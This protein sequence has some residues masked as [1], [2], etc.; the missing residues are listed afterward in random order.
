MLNLS[1][2]IKIFIQKL[3]FFP[4]QKT[5]KNYK[6]FAYSLAKII[7]FVKNTIIFFTLLKIF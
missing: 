1:F 6:K 3:Y 4:I 2:S 5:E 7:F